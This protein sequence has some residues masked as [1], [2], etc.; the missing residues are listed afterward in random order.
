MFSIY[1][2]AI[3]CGSSSVD[4]E[5]RLAISGGKKIDDTAPLQVKKSVVAIAKNPDFYSEVS[6]HRS[7]YCSGVIIAENIVLTAAHCADIRA[8]TLIVFGDELRVSA[9]EPA[10]YSRQ[11]TQAIKHPGYPDRIIYEN[12]MEIIRNDFID[13]PD[14]WLR[15][16]PGKKP[17]DLALLKF[18]GELPKGYG[19]ANLDFRTELPAGTKATLA[20][21]GITRTTNI[22]DTTHLRWVDEVNVHVS[23][24]EAN[25]RSWHLVGD[26][27]GLDD[28]TSGE[29]ARGA[30]SGDSGGPAFV[31]VGGEL[32]VSGILSLGEINNISAGSPAYFCLAHKTGEES[33]PGNI[34]TKIGDYRDWL[35]EASSRLGAEL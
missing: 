20:G 33:K 21:Y 14:S 24:E 8:A 29:H 23:S 13:S 4:K 2:L 28:L 1:A 12:A 35:I 3:S 30:C 32:K 5:S 15:D 18:S 16:N 26:T 27:V 19:P 31:D 11:V 34:Y 17:N 7:S 22:A 9:K 25:A 10:K 6:G